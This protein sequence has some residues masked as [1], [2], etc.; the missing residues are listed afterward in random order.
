MT[1]SPARAGQRSAAPGAAGKDAP[2][3][4]RLVV[5]SGPSGVGKGSVVAE[6]RRR[7]A[8]VWVSVSW[9]TRPPR[10]GETD[11]V[12]YHFVDRATFDEH[13]AAGEFLEYATY[14]EH[15]Y[16]TPRGPV[17]DHVATGRSAL[18]E[19]DLQGARMVRAAMPEAVLVFLAP[20]SW[21]ELVR[22]LTGRGTDDAA[23]IERRL[24]AARQEL[25]AQAEFDGVIVNDTVE[26][27]ADA[28]VN[29]YLN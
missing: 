14:A 8:D 22:R 20:P 9:T 18:L 2:G 4:G 11:G 5:L 24:A 29:S 27:A 13:A 26:H 3:H 6:L 23:T 28:L 21:D 19:I 12:E 7:H 25:A 17:L 16:G 15:S 10:P 1:E